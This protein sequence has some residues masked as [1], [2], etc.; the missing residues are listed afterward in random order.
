MC[1]I[2]HFERKA[3]ITDIREE[4]S[5]HMKKNVSRMLCL[6]LSFLTVTL[7][8]GN[9]VMAEENLQT[10]D[11]Q[12]VVEGE[13]SLEDITEQG[14]LSEGGSADVVVGEN[15]SDEDSSD[16]VED[17]VAAVED[18]GAVSVADSAETTVEVSDEQ[19]DT[20]ADS[21]ENSQIEEVFVAD[22]EVSDEE[23]GTESEEI[24]EENAEVTDDSQDESAVEENEVGVD[25]EDAVEG[26][27]LAEEYV[28]D[29]LIAELG[30]SEK[31]IEDYLN[32]QIESGINPVYY[33]SS[34]A[35]DNLNSNKRAFYNKLK[36]FFA[37]VAAGNQASTELKINTS[38]LGYKQWW[39][40]SDLGIAS[41]DNGQGAA[42]LKEKLIDSA[43]LYDAYESLLGDCPYEAYW[44]DG[45]VFSAS[46]E[47]KYVNGQYMISMP[48][49]TVKV[50]PKAAYKGSADYTVNQ[51]KM[52]S[53]ALAV[54]NVQNIIKD[55]AGYDDLSKLA[56]YRDAICKMTD[57][58]QQ[59]SESVGSSKDGNAWEIIYV[60]DGKA[61][62]KVVCE[63]YAKAFQYLCE[64][65]VFT[66]SSINCYTVSGYAK[67]GTH[68]WNIVHW[69]DGANYVVDVTFCDTTGSDKFFMLSPSSGNINDGYTFIV[70]DS[71]YKYS[72]SNDELDGG[73]YTTEQLTLK[74]VS[75]AKLTDFHI[76][77]N[78]DICAGDTV[79]FTLVREG[80]SDKTQFK[81]DYAKIGG[82]DV[83]PS[84]NANYGSRH[85]FEVTFSKSGNYELK[86][87]AKDSDGKTVSKII[88]VTVLSNGLTQFSDGKW[89][90]T[91]Y[92][93]VQTG[94]TGL[95]EKDG[96]L[97]YVQKGVVNWGVNGLIQY[98]GTWYYLNNSVVDDKFTGLVKYENKTY[99]V[100]K[101]VLNWGVKELI[102]YSGTWYYVNNST[103]AT[104]YTGLVQ[105]NN[106]WYYV[107]KGVLIWG[108]KTLVMHN[109]TWYY[110]NNSTV[111][112]NYTGLCQ[113]NGTW[114]YIQKGMLKWGV[115]TLV[116]YEG[117][118]YYVSNSKIDW[119]YTGMAEYK[120]DNYYVQKGQ[121]EWGVN[122]LTNVGGNWY[123]LSNST[124]KK[125]YTGLVQYN[126]NWFYVQKGELKW[127]VT[128]LVKYNG[129]W[130]YVTNSKVD[131]KYTGMCYYNGDNYYVQ[132][133][134]I[135]WGVNGLTNVGGTWYYLSNS[136][137]KKSYTGLVQYNG[138]W[139]YVQK[140]VLNWGVRTLTQYNETWYYVNNSTL[141]WNFTGIVSYNGSQYY[142]QK[143]VLKWGY[144]GTV[145]YNGKKYNVVNSTVK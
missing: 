137:V 130:Y 12:T 83:N 45:T 66:D 4:R 133:G 145:Q 90:Y 124:V 92:G 57:Y 62:T 72:Y 135:K 47:T 2:I 35:G 85:A 63:G 37:E 93:V 73:K 95:V 14:L 128:T 36:F 100:Q 111:D 131:W 43:G 40:A 27:D 113:Y 56:Y 55:A 70:Y 108:I 140:G 97:Y 81:L 84:A 54:T 120:G 20:T 125:S 25:V 132:N 49:I 82:T 116:Q 123:Y 118:W 16:S 41:L 129:N 51:T 65:T 52:Q 7:S 99:Y 80:G 9:V 60:F 53:A 112:W 143:G 26:E 38:E 24:S 88:T 23:L 119:N 136:A 59:A 21:Q 42:A 3:I 117:T 101:G 109:N 89:Y 17:T 139:F 91:K 121:I 96:K 71:E 141:D 105:Y 104:D 126:G 1:D 19:A 10:D 50:V 22:E 29:V 74:V 87:S 31:E 102:Q 138:K 114:Y 110:V 76:N 34:T 61:D 75:A 98:N 46:Y 28:E 44:V 77:Y 33:A 11:V 69:K 122:G 94:F 103:L 5:K 142:I 67:G 64:K 15:I 134:Q 86:F 106:N 115:K 79:Q 39:S 18:V 144:N 58:N 127:G 68:A 107:Q 32:Y 78:P 6:F 48:Y 30:G 8:L 13:T